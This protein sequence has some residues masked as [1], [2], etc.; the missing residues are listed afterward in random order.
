MFRFNPG[1]QSYQEINFNLYALQSNLTGIV[2]RQLNL[3]NTLYS[4]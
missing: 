1:I 3:L 4:V 2:T